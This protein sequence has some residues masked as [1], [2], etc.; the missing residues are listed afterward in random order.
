MQFLMFGQEIVGYI[1]LTQNGLL[2]SQTTKITKKT[3]LKCQIRME[4]GM[5]STALFLDMFYVKDIFVQDSKKEKS[6]REMESVLKGFVS[7]RL[8]SLQMTVEN[9]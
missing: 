2:E 5:M 1:F 9:H 3:V 4:D 6:A 7:A 8:G